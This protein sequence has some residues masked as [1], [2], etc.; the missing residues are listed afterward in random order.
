MLLA[1][2]STESFV[3]ILLITLLL[4]LLLLHFYFLTCLHGKSLASAAEIIVQ[5]AKRM[6]EAIKERVDHLSTQREN[7]ED[8]H[9]ELMKLRQRWRVKR[10]GASITGDLTYRSG[11]GTDRQTPCYIHETICKKHN[12]QHYRA[13]PNTAHGTAV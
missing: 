8:F 7:V 12:T 2:Q 1:N 9:S 10:A 6:A 13:E 4:L 11:E 5:G 3:C